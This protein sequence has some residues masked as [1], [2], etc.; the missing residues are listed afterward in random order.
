MTAQ[1]LSCSRT[2]TRIQTSEQAAIE[3][4]TYT[5]N[6]KEGQRESQQVW[7]GGAWVWDTHLSS[8]LC[9][10]TAAPTHT[11]TDMTANSRRSLWKRRHTHTHT[12]KRSL[13]LFSWTIPRHI[14]NLFDNI[15]AGGRISSNLP[16]CSLPAAFMYSLVWL[17]VCVCGCLETIANPHIYFDKWQ[18]CPSLCP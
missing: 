11:L 12:H 1:R 9:G 15:P 10:R 18:I 6:N 13:E 7:P 14:T 8:K 2:S 3:D 5:R 16:V 17:T 4:H